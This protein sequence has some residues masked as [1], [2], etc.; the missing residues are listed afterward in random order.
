MPGDLI[1][2]EESQSYI[3]KRRPRRPGMGSGNYKRRKGLT[4]AEKRRKRKGGA[5]NGGPGLHGAG[6]RPSTQR[7]KKGYLVK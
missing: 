7:Q 3:K 1:W 6:M 5:I 4:G 2:D